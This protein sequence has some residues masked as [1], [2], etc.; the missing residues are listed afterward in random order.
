MD[1]KTIQILSTGLSAV[2]DIKKGNADK[3]AA[4]FEA[5]QLVKNAKAKYAQ[6][7]RRAAEEQRKGRI[8][9]SNARAAF[10]GSGAAADAGTAQQLAK[11]RGVGD[12]NALAAMFQAKTESQGLR[13][14]AAGKRY[15]GKLAKQKGISSAL[16]R[17]TTLIP[18]DFSLSDL[19][20]KKSSARLNNA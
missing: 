10:A 18:A 17:A 9:E 7:T 5:A 19:F 8:M 6:G 15:E 11:I 2:G 12:Y 20:K 16:G 4:D 14:Q 1:P 3:K 13:T